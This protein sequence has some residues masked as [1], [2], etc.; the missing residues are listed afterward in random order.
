MGITYAI[1]SL[2]FAGVNDFVF[3]QYIHK[4]RE[5]LGWFVAAVGAVWTVVFAVAMY[6]T[7]G[8]LTWRAWW[9]SVGAGMASVLANLLFIGSFRAVPAGT[10]AMIYRLNLLIVAILGVTV[11]HESVTAWKIIGVALGLAAVLLIRNGN[12]SSEAT[13]ARWAV[14]ALAIACGLRACMGILYKVSSNEGIPQF[15][16]LAVGG[17]CWLIGGAV[18]ALLRR[19]PIRFTTG[20]L[21]WYSALSGGLVCGIVYFMLA[22]TQVADAS[23]VV[24]IAQLSFIVTTILGMSFHKEK[25]SPR[26]ILALTAAV[27]CIVAISRG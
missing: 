25:I 7:T 3:K 8:G 9:V 4:G 26:K 6:W 11:L 2:I 18:F 17:V 24:P 23:V 27:A 20:R 10:G 14:V 15:E 19:E 22:A 13:L 5:P 16:M 1:L 21:T 12:G